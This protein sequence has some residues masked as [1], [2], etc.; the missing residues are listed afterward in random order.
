M[1]TALP[2]DQNVKTTV[3]FHTK[4]V[5]NSLTPINSSSK[6]SHKN[7]SIKLPSPVNKVSSLSV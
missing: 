6:V 2:F 4:P 3:I 7:N 5:I 1:Q